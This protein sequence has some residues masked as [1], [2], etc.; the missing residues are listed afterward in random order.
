[1]RAA[2][3][4]NGRSPNPAYA[5]GWIWQYPVKA[6]LT[7]AIASGDLTRGNLA[8]LAGSLSGV[9]Y[10]G[11]LPTRTYV[12]SANDQI[13]RSSLVNGVDPDEPDGLTPLTDAFI[14]QIA[15]DFN[16]AAPCFVG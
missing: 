11:V 13:E 12:G 6:L 8:S 4:A 14:S 9:D 7:E 5:F 3:E 1:M 15:A 2:A 16:L 10:Q